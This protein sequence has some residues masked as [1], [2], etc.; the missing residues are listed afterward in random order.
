M[1]VHTGSGSWFLS[2]PDPEVKKAPDPGSGKLNTAV[3]HVFVGWCI[4]LFTQTD[5]EKANPKKGQTHYWTGSSYTWGY[6]FLQY[7]GSGMFIPDPGSRVF[8]IPDLVRVRI[9]DLNIFNPKKLFLRSGKYD[10]A[11]E[12]NRAPNPGSGSATLIFTPC[13]NHFFVRITN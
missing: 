11:L 8:K 4:L 10:S 9:Q 5:Q 2:I 6:G 7:W 12:V 3:P 1:D 13:W